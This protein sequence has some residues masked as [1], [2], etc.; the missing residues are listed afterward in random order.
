[1]T[2]FE[3]GAL[4]VDFANQEVTVDG[5]SVALTPTEYRLLVTRIRDQGQ[6][7]PPD[8]QVAWDDPSELL[9]AP[10]R[11]QYAV[12]RLRRKLGGNDE[13]PPTAGIGLRR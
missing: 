10:S 11:V 12:Q 9:Q 8:Q 2:V 5:R 7:L 4:R 13:D 1:M 3:D 6:V